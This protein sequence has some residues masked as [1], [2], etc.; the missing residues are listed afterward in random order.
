M[1]KPLVR[2]YFLFIIFSILLFSYENK[3]IGHDSDLVDTQ[4]DQVED[5]ARR[6]A[7]PDRGQKE[8]ANPKRSPRNFI[9]SSRALC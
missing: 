6:P 7:Q 2:F 1:K 8:G 5:S 3:T 4:K 9:S